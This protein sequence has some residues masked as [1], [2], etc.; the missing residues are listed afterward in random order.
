MCF[1][2]NRYNK[3]TESKEKLDGT[4]KKDG[5]QNIKY[6]KSS[7]FFMEPLVL[8]SKMRDVLLP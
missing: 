8:Q 5:K 3:C 4:I 7:L 1:V 6:R 2:H